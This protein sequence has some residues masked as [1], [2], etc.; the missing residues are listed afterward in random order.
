MLVSTD[1]SVLEYECGIKGVVSL[2]AVFHR[3]VIGVVVLLQFISPIWTCLT[4][5]L[6]LAVLAVDSTA[7]QHG[8]QAHIAISNKIK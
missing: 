7:Q 2:T 4:C 1:A 5:L 8:G 3:P 6:R